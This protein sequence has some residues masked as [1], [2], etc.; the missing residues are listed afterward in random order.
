[1]NEKILKKQGISKRQKVFAWMLLIAAGLTV[2]L[3]FEQIA[4][5]YVLATLFLVVLLLIVAFADLEKV[6][7]MDEEEPA[8]ASA[9]MSNDH[10]KT[11]TA[12]NYEKSGRMQSLG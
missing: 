5:I 6:G 11:D 2:L 3:Y 10:E 7:R 8:T 12:R 4:L 9:A 1:M